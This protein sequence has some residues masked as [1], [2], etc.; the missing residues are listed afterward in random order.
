MTKHRLL[1][2]YFANSF[3]NK[4]GSKCFFSLNVKERGTEPMNQEAF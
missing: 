4:F 3:Y 1:L 2:P